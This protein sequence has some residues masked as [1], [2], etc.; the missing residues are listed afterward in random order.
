MFCVYICVFFLSLSIKKFNKENL[1][2]LDAK[3]GTPK[4]AFGQKKKKG[5]TGIATLLQFIDWVL[6]KTF[7]E[8]AGNDFLWT[9]EYLSWL[10]WSLTLI[11]NIVQGN[12]FINCTS[13]KRVLQR[14]SKK[15]HFYRW[16][17]FSTFIVLIRIKSRNNF[18]N[19]NKI[20]WH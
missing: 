15:C 9:C 20:S 8:N 2:P 19:L 6:S 4:L 18:A 3:S 16:C 12:S 1:F 13:G 5:L 10:C 14:H 11:W 17:S 7:S